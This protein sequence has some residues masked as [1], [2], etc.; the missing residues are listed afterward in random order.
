MDNFLVNFWMK[1][2]D[3]FWKILDYSLVLVPIILRK[4]KT[5]QKLVK[6][7]SVL[8]RAVFDISELCSATILLTCQVVSHIVFTTHSWKMVA[9]AALLKQA[10]GTLSLSP[11]LFLPLQ[12]IFVILI[13]HLICQYWLYK[14]FSNPYS[15]VSECISLSVDRS[16]YLP[17]WGICI[18]L[19]LS[20]S[21][22][23][24][25]CICT[26]FSLS[27]HHNSFTLCLCL[28][29]S[30]SIPFFLSLCLSKSLHSFLSLSLTL[31]LSTCICTYFSLSIHHNSFT[32][33]L[34]LFCSLSIPFFLSLSISHSLWVFPFLSIPLSLSLFPFLFLS[35]F[36]WSFPILLLT[37]LVFSIFPFSLYRTLFF[38][39]SLVLS[40]SLFCSVLAS[41][42][43]SLSLSAS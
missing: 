21:L 18:S 3:N 7:L 43:L 29:C 10:F 15:T 5:K 4:K 33:C 38:Y 25:T 42:F 12:Q 26:Y 16:T 28:F 34:C 1:N 24:L 11:N 32:L 13:G 2:P 23:L 17:I 27:I 20:L 40:V 35:L 36:S 9:S 41:S 22:D 37:L 6:Y 39:P 30:L 19:S 8:I 14:V 31:S